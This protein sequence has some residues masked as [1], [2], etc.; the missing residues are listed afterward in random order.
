MKVLLISPKNKDAKG[1]IAI[2][3]EHYLNGLSALGKN[4]DLVNT[5]T[6]GKRSVNLS[7]KR[8]LKDEWTRTHRIMADLTTML[9]NNKYNVAHLNTSIGVFGIIRDYY[10][11]KRIVKKKIPLVVHF[12]CDI[13]FWTTN[14]IIK[15][16]L[17]KLLN[18]SKRNFVLCENSKKYLKDMFGVDSIKVPNFIEEELIVPNKLIN[19]EIK[20]V[21]FVGRGSLNKGAKEI[22]ALAE[23]FPSIKFELAGEVSQEVANWSQPSNLYLLGPQ[24]HEELLIYLDTSDL[25]FFPSHT[26]GFSM[27]LLESMARGVPSIA[28]DVGANLD[29]LENKGGIVV[30]AG[31]LN[32]MEEGFKKLSDPTIRKEMSVW[33]INKVLNNY[34]T[35]RV[36]EGLLEQ[37][38][39][40]K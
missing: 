34:I 32:A 24:S 12:H 37:Y 11:A 36:M 25:F 31:D 9:K 39:S 20:K 22:Y 4:Y 19:G 10:I 40:L 16:Y 1:G 21:F 18:I 6:V 7:A 23:K 29:M 8:N 15:Y 35:N 2:W 28:T 33:C 17:K 26:E 13:P 27:A 38:N 3:T 5:A 14:P 30:K